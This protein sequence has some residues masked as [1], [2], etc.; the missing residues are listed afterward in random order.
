SISLFQIERLACHPQKSLQSIPRYP[1]SFLIKI[2]SCIKTKLRINS[3]SGG[4]TQ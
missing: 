3:S 2:A 1:S 4:T